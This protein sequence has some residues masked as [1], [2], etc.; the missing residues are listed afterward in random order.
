MKH[1]FTSDQLLA[2]WEKYREYHEKGL[3]MSDIQREDRELYPPCSDS[4]WRSV[5]KACWESSNDLAPPGM[6]RRLRMQEGKAQV[7]PK[8]GV[9][10]L[11]PQEKKKSKMEQEET[12]SV[13]PIKSPEPAKKEEPDVLRL[14]YEGLGLIGQVIHAPSEQARAQFEAH[15][16]QCQPHM[17]EQAKKDITQELKDDDLFAM[18]VCGNPPA[19]EVLLK[20]AFTAID[21]AFK[22]GF[23][24]L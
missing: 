14:F 20:R 6:I 21:R 2:L 13:L 15:F 22:V 10:I 12:P 5:N 11:P 1:F 3:T 9:D 7:K 4:Y 24:A 8:E 18:H 17:T 19:R 16:F 23:T